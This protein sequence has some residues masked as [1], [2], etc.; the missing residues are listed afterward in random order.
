M[1]KYFI[2]PATELTKVNSIYVIEKPTTVRL[3]ND[4]TFFVCKLKS[5]STSKVLDSFK[6]FT[7]AEILEEMQKP[8]WQPL[9]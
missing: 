4:K 9:E 1:N 3:N 7:H 8:E 5:G 6:S 2:L